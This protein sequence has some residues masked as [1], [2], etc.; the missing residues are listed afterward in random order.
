MKKINGLKLPDAVGEIM[1]ALEESGH[2]A[3]IVGGCVRDVLRG[4]EPADWDMCTDASPRE[5]FAIFG[6]PEKKSEKDGE[7]YSGWRIFD[8]GA[9]HGTVGILINDKLYEV[10]TYRVDGNYA[11]NR[12]PDSVRFSRSI[13]DDLAR[14]DFT[15]NAMA[16]N[17]KRG[18]IDLFGGQ[19]DLQNGII[20][21][22]GNP[23]ERYL[24]DALRIMRAMRFSAQLSFSIETNTYEAMNKYAY[25]LHNIS[26]ERIREEFV[27]TLTGIGSLQSLD[28]CRKVID[29]IIPEAVPMFGLDQKNDYHCYDVW[30]HTLHVVHYV[31]N[32]VPLKL[33]AFFHDIG[34]PPC[35][36]LTEDGW[37]HFYG[38]EH[39]SAEMAESV[40]KRLKFDN[41]T[42]ALVKEL[43]WY[44]GIVFQQTEKHAK[45]MLNKF[46]AEKLDML[47][48][49]EIADV[50][51]QAPSCAEERIANI[52]KFRGITADILEQ[53]KCFSMRD[54]A[55]DGRDIL[56]LGV[57][58]GP[59]VGR[60]LKA[61]FSGVI[62]EKIP[63]EKEILRREAEKML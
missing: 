35:M 29:E 28:R 7:Y 11:D 49:L 38:H 19:E 30:Q 50:S 21:C 42:T 46:G 5:M 40:M 1:D 17:K 18:L 24:E 55:I 45:H 15:V 9:R 8:T 12:H 6:K 3:F 10:T 23:A 39:M 22:V 47:T 60:I 52:E 34:K 33:A 2:E 31:I 37:G 62:D 32:T 53:Q 57:P 61:L 58:Q 44:H 41:K 4:A 25:L 14:R 13:E 16:Y 26:E 43:I 27:K 20:R 51:S 56:E 36:T 59:E 48:E 54:M 63:N